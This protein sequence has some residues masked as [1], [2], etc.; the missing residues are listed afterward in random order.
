MEI[1]ETQILKYID[2]LYDVDYLAGIVTSVSLQELCQTIE[3]L[4]QCEDN[5]TVALTGLFIRDLVLCGNHHPDCKEFIENYPQSSVVKKLEELVSSPNCFTSYQAIYSLGK[6]CSYSSIN[7]LNK[8]FTQLRDT[9]PLILPRLVA[10]MSWLGA[11]NIWE[12]L[13]SML[14]SQI[15]TT[16]WSVLNILGE[17]IG[18]EPSLEDELFQHKWRYF[19][20][21]RQDSNPYVRAEAEYEYQLLNFR[22]KGKKLARAERKQRMKHLQR[23][24]E[25][26][27]RFN[28]ISV[29]FTND[30]S[31]QELTRYSIEEL[32]AFIEDI[33]QKES[34][35]CLKE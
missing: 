20:R 35:F 21:L 24:Y 19:D 11:E 17:F 32:E 4:L 18:D 25:P 1:I 31:K 22:L 33:A 29:A 16:R 3:K 14:D 23:T 2:R 34:F 10:E 8:A 15:Y 26:V 30:L 27:L 9:A 28:N 5:E 13:D 7:T 12:L 6:T